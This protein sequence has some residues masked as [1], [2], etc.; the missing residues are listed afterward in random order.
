MEK[1]Q[2]AKE[3][4]YLY[5]S[6]KYTQQAKIIKDERIQEIDNEIASASQTVEAYEQQLNQLLAA[7]K[8]YKQAQS[9]ISNWQAELQ[10]KMGQLAQLNQQHEDKNNQVYQKMNVIEEKYQEKVKEFNNLD[11][12]KVD[13]AK[14]AKL[15]DEL[16]NYFK[17][18]GYLE[19]VKFSEHLT[20]LKQNNA[21]Y[22][23]EFVVLDHDIIDLQNDIAHLDI[24]N[25]VDLLNQTYI[26]LDEAK[27][28][29]ARIEKVKASLIQLLIDLIEKHNANILDTYVYN[30]L[31][32]LDKIE[33]S[34][35]MEEVISKDLEEL[36][37]TLTNEEVVNNNLKR[38]NYI[39]NRLGEVDNTV[40]S[41]YYNLEE[42]RSLDE[43]RTTLS[44]HIKVLDN[45]VERTILVLNSDSMLRKIYNEYLTTKVQYSENQN[46]IIKLEDEVF[47]YTNQRKSLITNPYAKNELS[48]IDSEINNLNEQINDLKN[49]NIAIE[50]HNQEINKNHPDLFKIIVNKAMIEEKLP[51]IKNNLKLIEEKVEKLN[52][53]LVKN[54]EIV[55]EYDALEKELG[56][57]NE[58]LQTNNH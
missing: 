40:R 45:Y 38:L 41:Y 11:L 26:I 44:E 1:S 47:K 8:D 13:I 39:T 23:D 27:A 12:E 43:N 33:I 10:Q 46:K 55:D 19:A 9:T 18:E 35:K 54:Q 53:E 3:A 22:I 15:T 31:I 50:K 2:V 51:Q 48:A 58:F 24:E 4:L 42:K 6:D 30:R 20:E 7:E 5:F 32:D 49:E 52:V 36:K 17:N 37:T 28:E 14:V 57:L 34:K 29:K 16:V 25:P 56:D 21:Q